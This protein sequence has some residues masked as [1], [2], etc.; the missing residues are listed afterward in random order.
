MGASPWLFQFGLDYAASNEIIVVE[1]KLSMVTD[2]L[3]H[4]N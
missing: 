1:Y 3:N 4:P 2:L